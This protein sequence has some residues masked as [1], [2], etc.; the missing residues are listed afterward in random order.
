MSLQKLAE[1]CLREIVRLNGV[2]VSIISNIGPCFIIKFR[3][4]LQQVLDPTH[5][6][7]EG[8]ITLDD[9][10]TYEEEPVQILAREV[11]QLRN[12]HVPLVEVLWR[13][14]AVEEATWE[15]RD[16]IRVRYPHLSGDNDLGR[17]TPLPSRLNA[18][19]AVADR[20]SFPVAQ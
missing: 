2:S 17:E 16:S 8:T 9:N 11:K 18:A 15:T 19:V 3:K 13:N 1:L 7:P 14:H 4:G 12:K 10:L 6:L 20:P 5:R